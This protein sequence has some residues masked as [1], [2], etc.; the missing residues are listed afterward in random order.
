MNASAP[1][2]QID[3]ARWLQTFRSIA[4]GTDERTFIADNIPLSA[5]GNSAPVMDY[6]QARAIASA[7]AP[8][9]MNSLPLDWAARLS[10][11]GVNMNF[12]IVK[13]LPVLPP[14][15]YLEEAPPGLPYAALV[16]PRVL[17]LTYT[18][19]EME[20][21]AR[22]LG[23]E[24][25]PFPWDE[26][27]RLRLQCELDAVFA[28][29]YRLDRAD[30]EYI[31]DAPA[32]GASFPSLKANEIRRFGEYRTRRHVLAAWDRLA[33]GAPPDLAEPAA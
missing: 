10:V 25:P 7:L 11:G 14:E 4:R 12:Y 8:A 20:G 22:A 33:A 1:L 31:L 13:Q 19:H 30:L 15:A 23:Y 21:F 18:S 29:M 28:Q 16:L 26:E 24:G 9:N 6:E 27:R 3:Y 5:A 32:P 17:E 2:P